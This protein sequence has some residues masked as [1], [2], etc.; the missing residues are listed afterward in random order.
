M[1]SKKLV[2]MFGLL[3]AASFALADTSTNTSNSKNLPKVYYEVCKIGGEL[4]GKPLPE[5]KSETNTTLSWSDGEDTWELIL[6]LEDPGFY[7]IELPQVDL[8]KSTQASQSDDQSLLTRDLRIFSPGVG[9]GN[10]ELVKA[11][12]VT[13]ITGSNPLDQTLKFV[14]VTRDGVDVSS[15]YPAVHNVTQISG[16]KK[17]YI[18][19]AL[20]PV[21][22]FPLQNQTTQN[23]TTVC[24]DVPESM[25]HLQISG[26]FSK[27][28]P[29]LKVFNILQQTVLAA[30]SAL[31]NCN[32]AKGDCRSLQQKLDSAIAARN[33]KWND[34]YSTSD[35]NY[36]WPDAFKGIALPGGDSGA[37]G[38]AICQAQNENQRQL[39]RLHR[40]LC[41][42]ANFQNCP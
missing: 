19:T 41:N 36:I 29:P 42:P 11:T 37:I 5:S 25:S 32:S 3:G 14:S 34:L 27:I 30:R 38:A 15:D 39:C 26:F 16:S 17:T 7:P 4:N 10:T 12:S 35:F 6:A 22:N 18:S 23:L 1:K 20:G 2:L 21:N 33:V 40:G 31:A 24:T 9:D 8:Q 28:L 13:Q